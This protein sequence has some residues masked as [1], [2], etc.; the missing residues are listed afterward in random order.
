[1]IG[2]ASRPGSAPES[3]RERLRVLVVD[4]EDLVRLVLGHKLK[5]AG[6]D[7]VEARDGLDA[8]SHLDGV[9]IV[10]T[11]LNM[12]RCNGEQLCREIRTREAFSALPIVL[13]TGG[14]IDEARMQAAGCQAVLYKPLPDALGDYLRAAVRN[15]PA[16][17]RG[18]PPPR[19]RHSASTPAA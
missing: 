14:P 11:D 5:L 17:N 9:D 3:T 6:F 7:V 4:D 12:P 18:D 10:L 13:M 16:P 19:A 1:V 8:L 2:E 15:A